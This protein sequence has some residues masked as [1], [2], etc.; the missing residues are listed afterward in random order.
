MACKENKK[1]DKKEY[2]YQLRKEKN[3]HSWAKVW[4]S[5]SDGSWGSQIF[6]VKLYPMHQ[7][8]SQRRLSV[9]ATAFQIIHL[10]HSTSNKHTYTHSSVQTFLCSSQWENLSEYQLF[11]WIHQSLSTLQIKWPKYT[12]TGITREW[13]RFIIVYNVFIV[14]LL[15]SNSNIFFFHSSFC[16]VSY[17]P[18]K[19]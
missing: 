3:N 11:Q 18:V 6:Q 14:L 1:L 7:Y 16:T 8:P 19:V 4:G 15:R 9:P 5:L 17:I 2:A 10:C 12:D 13:S